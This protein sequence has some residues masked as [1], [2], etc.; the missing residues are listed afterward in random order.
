MKLLYI[1]HYKEGTG[2][3]NAAINYILALDS[4]GV[5]IVC[6]NIKLTNANPNIPHRIVELEQKTLS[7]ID[8]CIQHV[9]P[10]HLV[11]TTKFKKNIAYF[12]N[13]SYPI[14]QTMWFE[15][16]KIMDEIWVPNHTNK[17]DLLNCDN[18]LKVKVIPHTFYLDRYKVQYPSIGFKY[19]D[20]KFK[21]YAIAD[22]NDRKNVHTIIRCF[23]SEFSNDEPVT[24]VL[25]VKKFGLS[26]SELIDFA[27]RE[28]EYIKSNMRLY[29]K[30][31][32][33]IQEIVIG[34]D[35]DD[36]QIYGL[37]QSCDCFV[38][39]SHGEGW[40]IPSFDA[41]CFG[42]TPICSNEGGPALFI[43]QDNK[44]CGTLV[45]GI[46]GICKHADPSFPDLFTGKQH[47]FV[48]ND[49][50]IK[51]AMRYYYE[52]RLNID[53]SAG[54]KVAENYSFD[55]IGNL[56]KDSLND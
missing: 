21:F 55:K 20:S 41:M 12:V 3:S 37:H 53:R 22:L 35:L 8:H 4:I 43:P 26:P 45:D 14:N 1:G 52:N 15:N 44:D 29:A 11:G 33:Y 18:N 54:L 47:W 46:Y 9:L 30:P 31:E 28:C 24:L 2:W 38:G 48:P 36:D 13:E 51:K 7:N 27:T 42:K 10:H 56:I 19:N 39:P 49:L 17:D 16:L 34:H 25:K 23:H 5:D 6:R 32:S 40:S 50:D